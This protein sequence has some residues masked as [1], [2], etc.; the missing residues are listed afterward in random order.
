MGTSS[1][2]LTFENDENTSGYDYNIPLSNTSANTYTY[3]VVPKTN[4]VN[5]VFNITNTSGTFNFE[6]DN[7]KIQH[8]VSPLQPMYIAVMNNLTDYYTKGIVIGFRI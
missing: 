2:S 7:F 8:V 3:Y 6:I 1:L 5:K 4:L